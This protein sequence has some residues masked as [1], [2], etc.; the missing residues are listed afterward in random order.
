MEILRALGVTCQSLSP[1]QQAIFVVEDAICFSIVSNFQ[2]N[3]I[4]LAVP[5]LLI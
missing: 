2:R 4:Y 1:P 3:R 5:S